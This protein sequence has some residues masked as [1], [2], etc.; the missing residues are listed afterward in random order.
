MSEVSATQLHRNTTSIID[1]VTQGERVPVT[2]HGRT[3]AYL[4]PYTDLIRLT[5]LEAL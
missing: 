1:R 5:N 3:I 4:I 2:R